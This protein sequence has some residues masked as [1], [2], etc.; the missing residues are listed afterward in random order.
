[1]SADS[2]LNSIWIIAAAAT[3]L[4]FMV[5]EWH[6]QRDKRFARKLRR[7]LA[8]VVVLIAL[9]PTVSAT[10]DIVRLQCTDA[11]V[12]AAHQIRRAPVTRS[13]G[14]PG[15]Y[16][17]QLSEQL[18]NSRVFW[19]L[20]PLATRSFVWIAA[21]VLFTSPGACL[22]SYASRAPPALHTALQTSS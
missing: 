8:V 16:L 3:L 6:S 18:Q 10:D 19:P 7:G 9:L 4:V 2:V 5:A 20:W 13:R 1:M 22:R 14:S 21:L 11:P 12:S 15:F 17:A